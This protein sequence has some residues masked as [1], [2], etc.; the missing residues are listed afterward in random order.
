MKQP[1]RRELIQRLLALDSEIE[2]LMQECSPGYVGQW[3]ESIWRAVR[4]KVDVVLTEQIHDIVV[5]LAEMRVLRR[6]LRC[7]TGPGPCDDG[8]HSNIVAMCCDDLRDL[9]DRLGIQ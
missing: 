3:A 5:F 4:N 9:A 7:G 6:H 2:Q 1:S 8:G